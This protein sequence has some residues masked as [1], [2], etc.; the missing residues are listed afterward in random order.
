MAVHGF[1]THAAANRRKLWW[2]VAS[3]I[4][5]FELICAV[6]LIVLLALHD[7]Q[8]TIL[9]NPA[10]YA[11]RYVVPVG[12]LAYLLFRLFYVGHLKH[13]QSRLSVKLLKAEASNSYA[14]KRF[15][16]IGEQICM[17]AGV[18][19]PQFGIIDAP[20]PNALAVGANRDR[21][22]I[23]VTCGLL[24]ELDDDELATVIAHE[25]AHI[26]NGDTQI[27][28]ANYALMRTAINM[29][30]NNPLRMESWQ[31]LLLVVM[32]PFFLPLLLGGS[33][34]TMLAMQ[35]SFHARRGI[36]LTR[37]LIADGEAVRI[38]HFPDALISALRKVA[39]KG[40][41]NGSENFRL[42]LFCGNID[43]ENVTHPSTESRI[44]A[45]TR[46]SAGMIDDNRIRRDTRELSAAI[47]AAPVKRFGNRAEPDPGPP[48][49]M[50]GLLAILA[51]P[52]IWVEWH[53]QCVDY[54]Q[55]HERDKRDFMGL[56][57]KSY[58]PLAATLTFLVIF[59]WPSN[60]DF[61]G[62]IG[63]FNP[64]NLV[65]GFETPDGGLEMFKY[66]SAEASQKQG[67]LTFIVAAF[68][69]IASATPGLRERIY[70]HVDW[71]K[72][73]QKKSGNLWR[74]I[75]N[76]KDDRSIPDSLG[77]PSGGAG[78]NRENHG[79]AGF[80]SAEKPTMS[81]ALRRT[82][83]RAEIG[84]IPI[85]GFVAF[86]SAGPAT[87]NSSQ[88]GA[89]PEPSFSRRMFDEAADFAKGEAVERLSG[90]WITLGD[91]DDDERDERRRP[92][93]KRESFNERLERELA[94]LSGQPADAPAPNFE[95]R[96]FHERLE[97]QLANIAPQA[98]QPVAVQPTAVQPTGVQPTT[99]ARPSPF[100]ARPQG[101]GRKMA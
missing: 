27:I 21:G 29:Q 8:N 17:T 60:G 92:Q 73:K 88:P 35:L 98:V 75:M 79:A 48:P 58:L 32:L 3:Y 37:D 82:A 64:A 26:I 1:V 77:R 86:R 90:G 46:L 50:P 87:A 54:W 13:V 53:E 19:Q 94:K 30:V 91:D 25:A 22:L 14:E 71:E 56:T 80:S 83:S 97:S 85:G 55:W 39:G 63:I 41:F 96:S 66:A 9:T 78:P 34:V 67:Y 6:A 24:R 4:I 89:E 7:P 23:A 47:P 40:D 81:D 62:A 10:G 101:F 2:L 36:S 57:A 68:F 52:K 28:A 49:Q 38:T 18:R 76:G 51:R 65:A 59:H 31:Q 45:V 43:A 16:R 93:E 100:Q 74:N 84:G 15:L 11:V 69:I 95:P 72:Q 20:E 99:P 33:A 5:A 70:P 42:S 61:V 44:T 12:I